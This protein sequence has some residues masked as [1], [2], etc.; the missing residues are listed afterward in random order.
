MQRTEST[1]ESNALRT[2]H[3]HLSPGSP[4]PSIYGSSGKA[5]GFSVRWCLALDSVPHI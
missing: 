3:T 5:C 1:E 4:F 2:D